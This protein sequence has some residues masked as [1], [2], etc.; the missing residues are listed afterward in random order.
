MCATSLATV[1]PGKIR[2]VFPDEFIK[3]TTV[4]EQIDSIWETMLL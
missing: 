2:C 3:A 1:S 4:I